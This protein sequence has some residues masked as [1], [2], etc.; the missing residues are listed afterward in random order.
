MPLGVQGVRSLRA[1]S[2]SPLEQIQ[3]HLLSS[4]FGGVSRVLLSLL[5][6]PC[7]VCPPSGV[8]HPE[9]AGKDAHSQPCSRRLSL[10]QPKVF[11]SLLFPVRSLSLWVKHFP[12]SQ[13]TPKVGSRL[14]CGLCRRGWEGTFPALLTPQKSP[15]AVPS[16]QGRA[17]GAGGD[18]GQPWGSLTWELLRGITLF[19]AHMKYLPAKHSCMIPGPALAGDQRSCK[20]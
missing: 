17:A 13:L 12:R 1:I 18:V 6:K 9:A 7:C 8:R 20:I 14:C 3:H 4:V 19:S 15:R 16:P 10:Q 2:S 5:A 11:S